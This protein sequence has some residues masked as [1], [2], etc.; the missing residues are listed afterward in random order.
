MT[1]RKAAY[2]TKRKP[3]DEHDHQ[4]NVITWATMMEG[5]YPELCL[6]FAVPNGA[7]VSIGQAI[8]LKAEGLKAGVPD[9]MLPVARQGYHGL[10]VEMKRAGGEVR[11]TQVSWLDAL[12][13]QGYLATVCYGDQDAIDTITAYLGMPEHDRPEWY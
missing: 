8:K 4:A 1:Q 9:L 10:F 13:E 3:V 11:D 5:R 6:L 12:G 2:R 7:R